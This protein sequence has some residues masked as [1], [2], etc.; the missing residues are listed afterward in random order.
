MGVQ[1]ALR[2]HGVK[3]LCWFILH[4]WHKNQP[5]LGYSA[6]WCRKKGTW[7][8]TEPRELEQEV[9][10]YLLPRVSLLLLTFFSRT[11]THTGW[12]V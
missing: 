6:K 5:A 4:L 2:I 8:S 3:V 9:A 1:P 10:W 12:V 11:Y 7:T